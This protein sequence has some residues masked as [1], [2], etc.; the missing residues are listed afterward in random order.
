MT[1]IVLFFAYALSLLPLSVL[2]GLSD[3]L[4]FLLYHVARYR[5]GV[6]RQNLVSSFPEKTMGE[7]KD[8]ERKF[9][10]W[11]CDYSVEAIKLLTMSRAELDCRPRAVSASST[12]PCTAKPSTSSSSAN[13]RSIPREC[14]RQ[15]SRSCDSW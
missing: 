15:R 12:T 7:I 14:P 2:Y 13:A 5:R 11:F 8:I 6:V 3:V 10:R 1:R 4:A 9:Y